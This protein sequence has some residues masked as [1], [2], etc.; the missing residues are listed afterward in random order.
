MMSKA[1]VITARIRRMGKVIFSL[2][3]SVHTSR[4]GGTRSQVQVGGG[5]LPGPD[6][7]D[8]QVQVGGVPSLRSGGGTRSQVRGG[9]GTWSQ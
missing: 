3:V 4:G 1:T 7:G 6:R 5:R 9:G 2:C 8:S